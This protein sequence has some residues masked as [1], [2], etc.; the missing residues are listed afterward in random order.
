MDPGLKCRTNR[1]LVVINYGEILQTKDI[2]KENN[3]QWF[4]AGSSAPIELGNSLI[5][6]RWYCF[7]ISLQ[8]KFSQPF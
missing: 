6:L 1:I 3:A 4:G 2:R 7:L 8:Y 5:S